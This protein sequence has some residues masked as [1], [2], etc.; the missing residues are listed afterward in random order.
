MPI[1]RNVVAAALYAA[2]KFCGTS[3]KTLWYVTFL[4]NEV[5]KGRIEQV[6]GNIY[7]LRDD[8]YVYFFNAKK[9]VHLAPSL[10][11]QARRL[12]DKK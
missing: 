11:N 1:M 5:R 4:T 6:E 9:V 7:L 10:S 8:R 2:H 3:D 12:D